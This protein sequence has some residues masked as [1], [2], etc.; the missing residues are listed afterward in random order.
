[1]QVQNN[2]MTLCYTTTM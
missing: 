2:T 1:M